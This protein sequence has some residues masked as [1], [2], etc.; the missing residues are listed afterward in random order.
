MSN[1]QRG[2][3]TL[4]AEDEIT[5]DSVNLVGEGL[6]FN[7]NKGSAHQVL[8][9][10]TN[11]EQNFKAITIPPLSIDTAEIKDD[12]VT[13]AKLADDIS[14]STTGNIQATGSGSISTENGNIG[15]EAGKVISNTIGKFSGTN[16]TIE[17]H[18]VLSANKNIDLTGTGA[19]TT[20]GVIT[21][22]NNINCEDLTGNDI[23]VNG[24]LS[25]TTGKIFTNTIT[26]QAASGSIT[27]E[28]PIT[29]TTN[30]GISTQGTGGITI[31][32]SGNFQTGSGK[33]ITDTIGK[34]T[35]SE[36]SVEDHL[37]LT[38]NKNLTLS[39]TGAIS[40]EGEI[41]TTGNMNCEDLTAN[42]IIT[43][44]NLS[45]TTGKVETNT[46]AKESG[47]DI[48]IEDPIDCGSKNITTTGQVSAGTLS[49]TTFSPASVSVTGN[50]ETTGGKVKT[51]T[52]AKSSGTNIT[53]ED[54]ID[55]G[56]NNIKTTS[57]KVLTNTIGKS[58]GTN[59]TIEDPIDCGSNA[60][61]TLGTINMGAIS[62]TG[63]IVTSGGDITAHGAV[64]SA[65]IEATGN[66]ET[67]G[68]NLVANGAVNSASVSA[69]GNISTGSGNITTTT[70]SMGCLNLQATGL[71]EGVN[72]TI[73]NTISSTSVIF[74]NLP[75]SAP[76][77]TGQL[78]ND[79]GTLK[80]A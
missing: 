66:I 5:A 44:G 75:T 80:I 11:G 68:G 49:V 6:F 15:T 61:T 1:R 18:I 48:T 78:W 45:T 19:I 9:V 32:G 76:A 56:A 58:S 28:H 13:G 64:R 57:G 29:M 38:A 34:N 25:T 39:G 73:H 72:L 70:G 12:A 10:D 17:D 4:S 59:I 14:I 69:T 46:I 74:A 62:A 54:P 42:D 23:I 35:G 20:E 2:G 79:S 24:N 60:I 71:I 33:V 77:T 26:R 51:N 37:N 31:T 55:S 27:I 63:N 65:T 8:Q 21:T 22:T 7:G 41:T 3:K 50:L 43:N 53:I 40:A 16:I 67:S 47:T 30:M 52:I 36:V